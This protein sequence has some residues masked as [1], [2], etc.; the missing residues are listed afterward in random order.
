MAIRSLPVIDLSRLYDGGPDGLHRVA[1]EIG[2]AC[3]D[4]GFFYI[5]G[6]PVP[7]RLR[8]EV[9]AQAHRFFGSSEAIKGA[10]SFDRSAHNRGYI[11][12]SVESLDP[13]RGPDRKE[14]FNIGLDLEAADPEVVTGKPFRGVNLWPELPG[15]RDTVLEYYA[16]M[17]KLGR[18]LHRAVAVDLGLPQTYFDDKFRRPL[19]TL[20][21]LHYPALPANGGTGELGAGQHTDY[22][23]ITLLSTDDVGG[24]EVRLR[25]GD[26]LEAPPIPGA[27]VCNIG[28]CL[29]RWTNDIYVSTPHRVVSPPERERFSVAF[30]LDADPDVV[31]SCLETC[32][33]PGAEPLYPPVSVADYLRRRLDATYQAAPAAT[34]P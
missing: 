22:G 17:L 15:F 9:F 4:L 31:V 33:T 26:W 6:T 8:D 5:S 34:P 14:A 3:R 13:A 16:A 7:S 10:V 29:M 20:R 25:D 32:R 27:F 30:F 23:N 11:A 21:L 19:A 18:D 24:L 12:T 2:S 28:D 1:E